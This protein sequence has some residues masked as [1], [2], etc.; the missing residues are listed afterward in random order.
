MFEFSDGLVLLVKQD[1]AT[2]QMLEPLF[3]KLA[4]RELPFSVLTQDDPSFPEALS[5]LGS[6]RQA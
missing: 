5:E 1:C 2:C 4:Q 6:G 3:A